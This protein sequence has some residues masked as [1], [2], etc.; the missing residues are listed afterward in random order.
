MPFG[1]LEA[2]AY[3][4]IV[5]LQ[6]KR[7]LPSFPTGYRW[8]CSSFYD[9]PGNSLVHQV[10]AALTSTVA[11]SVTD[12]QARSWPAVAL[13]LR[14]KGTKVLWW[15][16]L[17]IKRQRSQIPLIFTGDKPEFMKTGLGRKCRI[18]TPGSLVSKILS[19]NQVYLLGSSLCFLPEAPYSLIQP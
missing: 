3:S 6:V 10:L 15:T 19:L 4:G 18:E 2:S 17:S 13:S 9:I 16:I 1:L 11:V 5:F 12:S 7:C 8:A 14:S